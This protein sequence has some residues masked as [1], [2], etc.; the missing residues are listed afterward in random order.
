MDQG[1][2]KTKIA[3]EVTPESPEKPILNEWDRRV[4]AVQK[5]VRK[6]GARAVHLNAVLQ[7]LGY[8]RHWRR[9]L[10]ANKQIQVNGTMPRK[11][12]VDMLWWLCTPGKDEITIEERSFKL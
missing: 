6:M 2:T 4:S 10:A 1:E 7:A 3:E 8:N 5:A 12:R 9:K 11:R